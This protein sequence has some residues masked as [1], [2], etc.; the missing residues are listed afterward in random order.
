M[1]CFP[2]ETE[3]MVWMSIFMGVGRMHW[4]RGGRVGQRRKD[5]VI[6]TSTWLLADH[7]HTYIYSAVQVIYII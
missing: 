3:D 6:A 7:K 4:V 1:L 5:R 2:E